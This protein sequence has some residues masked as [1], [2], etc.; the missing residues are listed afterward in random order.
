MLDII[1]IETN[2]YEQTYLYSERAQPKLV[3]MREFTLWLHHVD[4]FERCKEKYADAR[5]LEVFFAQS[6]ENMKLLSGYTKPSK[7]LMVIIINPAA[8]AHVFVD[9]DAENTPIIEVHISI[10]TLAKIFGISPMSHTRR[11]VPLQDLCKR[12][13]HGYRR[14]GQYVD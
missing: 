5:G 9:P 3:G 4:R 13:S 10:P 8:N 11:Q 14:N 1:C 12:V 6:I 2:G 7:A